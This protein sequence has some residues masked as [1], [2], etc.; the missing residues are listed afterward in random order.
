MMNIGMITM[1]I[2]CAH[3]YWREHDAQAP[4]VRSIERPLDVMEGVVDCLCTGPQ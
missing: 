4:C 2:A 1:V 3:A